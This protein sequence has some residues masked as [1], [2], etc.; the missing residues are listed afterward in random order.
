MDLFRMKC[1]IAAAETGNLT[2]AAEKMSITQ[3]AMSFQIRELEKEIQADLVVRS[4]GGITLTEA[5]RLTEYGFKRIIAGYER[6]VSEV[7][8]SGTEKKRLIVGYHGNVEWAG[9]NAK[10]AAF[11]EKYPHVEVAV[12][13]QNWKELA[14]YLEMGVVDCAFLE[15]HELNNR[16]ALQSIPFLTD[17]P[18]VAM[19]PVHPLAGREIIYPEDLKDEKILMNNHAS[20]SIDAMFELM[21]SIGV[22][23]EHM[24]FFDNLETP[25][26][27]A[28]ANQGLAVMPASFGF[29]SD[30]L[31]FIDYA[32]TGAEVRFVMAFRKEVRDTVGMFRDFLQVDN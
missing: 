17:H 7:R 10:I 20:Q 6:L 32:V 11:S 21:R 1:F 27:M 26:A 28:A 23:E 12:V 24:V 2:K 5:G 19:S 16:Y 3:P 18:C 13:K 30:V 25:M 4:R 14:D 31:R 8:A 9:L 29:Q 15:E 22:P